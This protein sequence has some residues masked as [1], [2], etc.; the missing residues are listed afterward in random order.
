[1]TT[2][3]QSF[4]ILIAEDNDV[5]R[6]LM[7]SILKTQGYNVFGAADGDQAIQ[8]IQ[9]NPI[10]M[11][12]V[13]I[14]MDPVGGF[15]FI[16]H[17]IVRGN[18]LPTV[19]V[20]ADK[21]ADILIEASNLGVRR[22][23]QKPIVP[24]RILETTQRVLKQAGHN[25]SILASEKRKIKFTP[26]EL[27]EKAIALA[28]L[29]A[30]GKKGGPFGAVLADDEGKVISEGVS[31]ALNRADP[32]AHAEVMAIRKA[33]ELL[34]TADLSDYILYCSSLPTAMGQALIRSV[35]IKNVYF[36]LT[37]D[38]INRF[39]P[40]A[41]AAEPQYQQLGHDSA[42]EMFKSYGI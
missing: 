25:F 27:M 39:R 42:I 26:E 6:E 17:L 38:E 15:E 41:H 29:N 16:K 21:S 35:G 33:A 23:L 24:E 11:A 40:K 30:E 34:G 19:I 36:G 28:A 22:I 2:A 12:F 31:G 10:D 4:N 3:E 5:T 20:T 1:M 32:V 14:N 13:D 18:K 7:A 9:T 37:H 8:V